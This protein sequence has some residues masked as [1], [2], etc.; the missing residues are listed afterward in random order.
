MALRI[1]EGSSASNTSE[2]ARER[3]T[4]SGAEPGDTVV[5]LSLVRSPV[6]AMH[7]PEC[8]CRIVGR[9]DKRYCSNRCRQAAYRRPKGGE[10]VTAMEP[11]GRFACVH[12]GSRGDT[13]WGSLTRPLCL[14]CCLPGLR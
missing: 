4:A 3:V 13:T 5:K 8:H 2:R 7:C 14:D 11:V 10:R 6:T 12:C 1:D 9:S